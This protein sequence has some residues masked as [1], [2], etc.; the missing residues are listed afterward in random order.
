M[1]RFLIVCLVFLLIAGCKASPHSFFPQ[2]SK[3]TV[4]Y[5]GVV[6]GEILLDDTTPACALITPVFIKGK[7]VIPVLSKTFKDRC[8]SVGDKI[9]VAEE[10]QNEFYSYYS[11]HSNI[12]K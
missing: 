4:L 11:W 6:V 3:K 9:I 7:G 2:E 8:P 10:R 1:K 12:P 5:E